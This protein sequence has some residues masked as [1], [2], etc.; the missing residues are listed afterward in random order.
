MD[1]KW[2]GPYKI[3]REIGKGLCGIEHVEDKTVIGRV[4]GAHLKQYLIPDEKV[5]S[6][7]T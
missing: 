7:C 2:L 5:H 3:I 4:H 6:G 1:F